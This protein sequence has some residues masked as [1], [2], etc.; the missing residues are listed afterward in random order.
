MAESKRVVIDLSQDDEDRKLT[1]PN[2]PLHA[3]GS[4]SD[5]EE[6]DFRVSAKNVLLTYSQSGD[7]TAED[8]SS[9]VLDICKSKGWAVKSY[10]ASTEKHSD[11]ENHVHIGLKFSKR[12]NIKDSRVFDYTCDP[13][14]CCSKTFL[15]FGKWLTDWEFML[16]SFD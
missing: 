2:S 13:S 7:H 4:D 6:G 9:Y 14:Y 12:P 15:C 3:A 5:G 1:P 16:A 11:G 10:C 8:L